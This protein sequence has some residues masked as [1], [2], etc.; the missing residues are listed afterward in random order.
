MDENQQIIDIPDTD[1]ELLAECEVQTFRSGGKGGQHVNKTETGVR[2]IHLPTGTV[3]TCTTERSQYRNKMLA[4]R[5]LRKKLEKK[6][7][8]RPERVP[9]AKPAA[10]REKE[11]LAKQRK[12]A[13]K[14]LRKPPELP[15]EE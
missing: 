3:T 1:D 4:V 8:V 15:D 2:L 7:I 12:S 11:K 14:Q 9:T 10:V 5:R 13:K 6:N